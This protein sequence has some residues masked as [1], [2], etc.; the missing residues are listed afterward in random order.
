MGLP[1]KAP[2][3]RANLCPIFHILAD[4]RRRGPV[5]MSARKILIK[6]ALVF[7]VQAIKV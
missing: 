2:L 5:E 6:K 4:M 7:D 1:G 3:E